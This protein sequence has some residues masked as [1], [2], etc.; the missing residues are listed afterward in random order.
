M[1]PTVIFPCATTAGVRW[2]LHGCYI[3]FMGCP[4]LPFHYQTLFVRLVAPCFYACFC[5]ALTPQEFKEKFVDFSACQRPWMKVLLEPDL[6]LARPHVKPYCG[7]ALVLGLYATLLNPLFLAPF[8]MC[9]KGM[10]TTMNLIVCKDIIR[11]QL[12]DIMM[13]L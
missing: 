2:V 7:N 5:L 12:Y 6:H 3:L 11:L 8:V 10:V 13:W 1:L 4:L 9:F